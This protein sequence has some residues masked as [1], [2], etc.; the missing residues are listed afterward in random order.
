MVTI[1]VAAME[2]LVVGGTVFDDSRAFLDDDRFPP[3]GVPYDRDFL[4]GDVSIADRAAGK[5]QSPAVIDV[6]RG[7]TGRPHPNRAHGHGRYRKRYNLFHG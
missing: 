7:L 4:L 1:G 6:G 3:G 5:A 2:F